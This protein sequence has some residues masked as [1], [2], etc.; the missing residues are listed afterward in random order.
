MECVSQTTVGD[1]AYQYDVLSFSLANYLGWRR[2]HVQNVEFPLLISTSYNISNNNNN[3]F[4]II[5]ISSSSSSSSSCNIATT[6][7]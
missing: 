7:E 2:R 3:F 1:T 4:F 5:I 6:E